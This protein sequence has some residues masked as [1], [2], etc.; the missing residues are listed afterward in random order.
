MRFERKKQIT[1]F[2][3]VVIVFISMRAALGEEALVYNF[4]VNSGFTDDWAAP[5]LTDFTIRLLNTQTPWKAMRRDRLSRLISRWPVDNKRGL[6]F[7]TR[8]AIRQHV[9]A[10]YLIEG[11]LENDRSG[12]KFIGT[13]IDPDNGGVTDLSFQMKKFDI[14]N[15]QKKLVQNIKK[16]LRED[17]N[18]KTQML[19]GTGDSDA[20][21]L[22]WK[23]V[24]LYEK[25]DADKALSLFEKSAARD[26][27]Y[28]EPA[29]MAGRV[30]LDKA[31]FNKAV[32][33]FRR[34]A[35]D[36]PADARPHFFLGLTY[37]LQRMNPPARAAFQKAV[38]LDPGN[39]EYHYQ[40]GLMDKE[41]FRY[42]DAVE[43]LEKAVKIDS[44]LYDAWYQ[45]AVIFSSAKQQ[46]KTLE[47]LDKAAT[48][49]DRALFV[50]IRNDADFAW[51][52][53]NGKFQTIL[54]RQPK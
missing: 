32:E 10:K 25:G 33:R 30:L 12:F 43:N 13:L 37:Y 35:D 45:L 4:E 9:G 49:G 21:R 23:G 38:E 22:F 7:E 28:I 51:L 15:A 14:A 39:P 11:R 46:H 53:N 18:P 48:W 50:K 42:D 54:I 2:A 40:L 27:A 34:A 17:F 31:L 44:S 36:W 6:S 24:R 3:A 5:A 19:Q 8:D 41:T 47:C 16:A 52:H 29:L 26:K 1:L 20:Y